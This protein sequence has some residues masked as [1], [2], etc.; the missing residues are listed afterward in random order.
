MFTGGERGIRTL[1]SDTIGTLAFQASQFS[2]SCTSPK[3]QHQLF[4]VLMYKK[5]LIP[6]EKQEKSSIIL[7]FLFK[8]KIEKQR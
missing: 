2:H 6:R 8:R 3:P 4:G 1:G 5:I 7:Q